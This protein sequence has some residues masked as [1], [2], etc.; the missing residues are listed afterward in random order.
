[1][2]HDVLQSLL[3][4]PLRVNEIFLLKFPVHD[5]VKSGA[6]NPWCSHHCATI[7]QRCRRQKVLERDGISKT[8]V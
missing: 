3:S 5:D 1:M 2:I 4:D 8:R 7:L 6:S